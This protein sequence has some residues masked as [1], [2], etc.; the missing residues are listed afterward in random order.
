MIRICKHQDMTHIIKRDSWNISQSYHEHFDQDL[1][2]RAIFFSISTTSPLNN[3]QIFP[4]IP[5]SI[6]SYFVCHAKNTT[7]ATIASSWIKTRSHR[8]SSRMVHHQFKGWLD[9][10]GRRM[11]RKNPYIWDIVHDGND[12]GITV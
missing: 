7:E 5:F 10:P 11:T 3:S 2:S 9:S 8:P 6:F 4:D 1:I 12:D